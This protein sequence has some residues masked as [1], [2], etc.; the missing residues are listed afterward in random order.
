M[1][2]ILKPYKAILAIPRHRWL[3]ISIHTFSMKTD[4][5][6]RSLSKGRFIRGKVLK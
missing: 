1:V 4:G 3:Q 6:M 5:R 2:A